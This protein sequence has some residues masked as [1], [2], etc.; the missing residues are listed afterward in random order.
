MSNAKVNRI[1]RRFPL[2]INRA[3]LVKHVAPSIIAGIVTKDDVSAWDKATNTIWLD[4][5][6][7]TQRKW[8]AFRHELDH[9]LN[10]VRDEERGGI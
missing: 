4:K 6:V 5:T 8:E 10:D 1:P 7:S 9:A 3:I 2:G